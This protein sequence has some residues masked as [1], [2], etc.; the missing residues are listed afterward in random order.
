MRRR[1][2]EGYRMRLYGMSLI[3]LIYYAVQWRDCVYTLTEFQVIFH[4]TLLTP[5]IFNVKNLCTPSLE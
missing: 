1:N 2:I 4:I 5:T 3:R